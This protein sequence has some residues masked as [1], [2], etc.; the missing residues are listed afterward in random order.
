MTA[1]FDFSFFVHI[2]ARHLP[3]LIF[4]LYV[5]LFDVT[6]C[7]MNDVWKA[8]NLCMHDPAGVPIAVGK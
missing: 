6:R 2:S 4:P 3:G 5:S 1:S 8:V 7:E